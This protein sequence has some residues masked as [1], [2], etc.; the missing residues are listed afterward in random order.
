MTIHKDEIERCIATNGNKLSAARKIYLSYPTA[1]FGDDYDVEFEIRDKIASFFE[2]DIHCVQF[3]G[4][5]KTGWSFHARKAFQKGESDLDAA[6]ISPEKFLSYM[7]L[8]SISTKDY[9]DLSGF[10]RT[11]EGVSHSK[12]MQDNIARHTMINMKIM[13][14]GKEKNRTREFFNKLTREY[15]DLFGDISVAIYGSAYFFENK[16]RLGFPSRREAL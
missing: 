5:A 7:K 11:R 8:L 14:S 15:N 1:A 3:T 9:T 6:I 16:Q 2:V 12:I 4:S 10:S 13:P